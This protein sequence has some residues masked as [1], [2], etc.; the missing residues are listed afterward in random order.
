MHCRQARPQTRPLSQMHAAIVSRHAGGM[1]RD[2]RARPCDGRG[3]P[4]RR[5][6]RCRGLPDVAVARPRRGIRAEI[7]QKWKRPQGYRE[8]RGRPVGFSGRAAPS[9]HAG[10]C[11]ERGLRGDGDGLSLRIRLRGDVPLFGIDAEMLLELRCALLRLR[12]PRCGLLRT[13]EKSLVLQQR[14]ELQRRRQHTAK[15][16]VRFPA[17]FVAQVLYPG[18][19]NAATIF[20]TCNNGKTLVTLD[21]TNKTANN[22]PATIN[23]TAIDWTQPTN[24]DRSQGGPQSAGAHGTSRYH[25]DRINGTLTIDNRLC[26]QNGRC[27]HLSPDPVRCTKS[28]VPATKF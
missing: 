19:A 8:R 16:P 6:R 18:F 12:P 5:E 17:P 26:F 3:R 7:G 11:Q 22:F 13:P 14:P 25:L 24:I 20:L 21:M 4:C 2:R 28:S 10:F 9:L 1:G 27:V 23:E 15:M